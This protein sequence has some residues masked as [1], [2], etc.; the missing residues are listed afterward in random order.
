MLQERE[1]GG[2]VS[3]LTSW[4][5]GRR[6]KRNPEIFFDG[7]ATKLDKYTREYK[8]R[9]GD[10]ADPDEDDIDEVAVVLAGHGKKHG[11]NM[12]MDGEFE[13]M[14]ALSQVRT[15]TSGSPS[16]NTRGQPR[17]NIAILEVS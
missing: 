10:D 1:R 17:S 7:V 14:P 5:L 15:C 13:N 3:Q 8:K 9:K 16:I 2:P 4:S 6:P 12:M 11:R